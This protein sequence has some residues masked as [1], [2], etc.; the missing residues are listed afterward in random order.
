MKLFS[1]KVALSFL[2]LLIVLCHSCTTTEQVATDTAGKPKVPAVE[3]KPKEQLAVKTPSEPSNIVAEIA[4][5]LITAQEL[6]QRMMRKI[7]L[8][9]SGR[10]EDY[11]ARAEPVTAKAELMEMLVEKAIIL[12]ARKQDYLEDETIQAHL[13]R[14]KQTYLTNLLLGEYLQDKINVTD[15][16]IDERIKAN[17]RLDRMRAEIMLE[18]EKADELIDQFYSQ[19]CEKLDVQK[20]TGNFSRAAQIYRRLLS[21]SQLLGR[22]RFVRGKQ[23]RE[24]VTPEEKNIVLAAFGTGGK[25]T[26]KDWLDAVHEFSPPSRPKDLHTPE[27]VERFLSGIIRPPVFAA[28][29]TARGLDKDQDL[30]KQMREREDGFVYGEAMKAL[31]KVITDPTT[32]QIIAYFNRNKEEFSAPDTLKIDQIWC[33]DFRTAWKV[34]A[35]LIDGRDFGSVRKKYSLDKRGGPFEVYRYSEGIFF[36]DL[37]NAEVDRIL[38]PLKG[39]HDSQ[40][41]WRIVKIL[42]KIPGIETEYTS[43]MD[44]DI[45]SMVREEQRLALFRRHGRQALSVHSYRIYPEKIKDPLDIP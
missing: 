44:G 22:M 9:F 30:L 17:P 10:D 4:D 41:K 13:R 40:V 21:Q 31:F 33:R 8:G 29:A 7:D 34:K 27:G 43:P 2:G 45:A 25:I 6:E 26:L 11:N 35:E 20:L 32:E 1:S 18:S 24:Q 16:E 15:S 5:Y 38:D 23:I 12:E 28:E 19:L 39:L 37:W 3:Q 42:K 14:F 36:E